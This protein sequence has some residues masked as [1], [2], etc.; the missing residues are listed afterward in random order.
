LRTAP[1]WAITQRV[2]VILLSLSQW[3]GIPVCYEKNRYTQCLLTFFPFKNSFNIFSNMLSRFFK[4]SIYF[5]FLQNSALLQLYTSASNCKGV[6]NIPGSHFVSL[7]GS[8]VAFLIMSVA[9]Q[10]R[11]PFNANF[12]R[13][14][15]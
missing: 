6:E 5:G 9:S 13:E 12:G 4:W 1:F 8:F 14:N 11:C 2:V 10:N 7:F 15:R 3:P